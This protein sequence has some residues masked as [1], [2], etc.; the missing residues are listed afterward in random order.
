MKRNLPIVCLLCF[1]ASNIACAQQTPAD[2]PETV[3]TVTA[4]RPDA[5]LRLL[6]LSSRGD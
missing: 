5:L 6:V 3:I 2:K 4:D 1:C